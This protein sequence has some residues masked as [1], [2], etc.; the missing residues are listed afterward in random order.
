MGFNDRLIYPRP[1]SQFLSVDKGPPL[2]NASC[3][4]CG[5]ADIRRYP[6]GWYKGPR[7]VV[8]CQDCFHS[9][10]VERPGPDEPWP[11]FRASGYDWDVPLAERA[12]RPEVL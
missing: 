7:I 3:S 6:I 2:A 5:G 4:E 10:A 8:K 9:L 1:T 11:P 12:A